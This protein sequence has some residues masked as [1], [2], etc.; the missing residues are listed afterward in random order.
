MKAEENKKDQEKFGDK[1]S[2]PKTSKKKM[3]KETEEEDE[4]MKKLGDP[5]V[6]RVKKHLPEHKNLGPSGSEWDV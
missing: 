2:S 6:E 5:V 3:R 4:E 1:K